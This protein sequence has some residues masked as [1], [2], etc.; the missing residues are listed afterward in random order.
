LDENTGRNFVKSI[1]HIYADLSKLY[2][3]HRLTSSFHQNTFKSYIKTGAYLFGTCKQYSSV[4]PLRS[5][6]TAVLGVLR[7]YETSV[8]EARS[9]AEA[10]GQ[11]KGPLQVRTAVR[12]IGGMN[13]FID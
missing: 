9:V 12:L 8:G 4:S 1:L 10:D 3:L 11:A 2:E 13:E 5:R 6:P 7:L